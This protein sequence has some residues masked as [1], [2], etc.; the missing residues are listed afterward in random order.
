MPSKS[1]EQ[2]REIAA[3]QGPI[4]LAIITVS[5]TRTRENDS[6]GDLIEQRAVSAGHMVVFRAIVRDEP[7]QIGALLDRIIAETSARLLLFTGG[8]G[9][10]PRDTT[11]DVISR[12]IEKPMP[13]FGEL[14]RMLSFAEV[15]PAAMLSRA[16]AG[17]YRGRL[18]FSMPGS[19]NAV[20]VAMDKLIIPEIEHLA[21]EVVR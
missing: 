16:T 5:D 13:G 2:H 6:G 3:R 11:Y 9:I 19:P 17:V 14:F 4:P 12:R 20:Q 10:A 21:W 7:D 18:V 1:T 8:T 15:G